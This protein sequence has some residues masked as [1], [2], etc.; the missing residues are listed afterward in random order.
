MVGLEAKPMTQVNQRL[1]EQA[2]ALSA[3]EKIKLVEELLAS[4]DPADQKE[5]DAAW[6]EEAERRLADYRAGRTTAIDAEEVFREL[7]GRRK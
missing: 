6:A 2:L 4:L 1:I 7:R 5:I 3:E